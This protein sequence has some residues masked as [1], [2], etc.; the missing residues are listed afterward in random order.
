MDYSVLV[1]AAGKR[2]GEGISYE[3]ALSKFK[4]NISVLEKTLSI[5]LEDKKCKQIVVVT[6]T[7]DLAT[8]VT[9]KRAGKIIYVKGGETRHDS[10]SNGLLAVSEDT[11]LIHDGVRPWVKQNYIDGLLEAM[12]KEKAAVLAVPVRNMMR[13]ENDGY[14][15]EVVN[16]EHVYTIQ[17]PQAY[18]TEFII[19]CYIKAKEDGIIQESVDIKDDSELVS[20]VSQEPIA[21]VSGDIYNTR[22][23]PKQNQ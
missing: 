23:L 9:Q 2:A 20:K 4:G 11:V 6:N 8:L 1:V 19:D 12:K 3:K 21:V 22:F 5:F 10:V 17:T 15:G 14:L 7:A 18:Q 16:T 13:Y